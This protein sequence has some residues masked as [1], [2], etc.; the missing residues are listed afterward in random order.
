MLGRL[1][2]RNRALNDLGRADLGSLRPVRA[3]RLHGQT[4]AENRVVANLMDLVRPDV[5]PWR[6]LEAHDLAGARRLGATVSLLD[7]R[8]ELVDREVVAHRITE[9]L[10]DVTA[11]IGE[12]LGGVS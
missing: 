9:L 2:Q 1:D 7:E 6:R 12:R 10:G 5:Q 3:D 8:A 11:V 4:M